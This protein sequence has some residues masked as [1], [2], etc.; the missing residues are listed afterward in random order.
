MKVVMIAISNIILYNNRNMT[1]PVG[2]DE[3]NEILIDMNDLN[4]K[5]ISEK[6]IKTVKLEN[7]KDDFSEDVLNTIEVLELENI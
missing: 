7:E 6:K 4:L 5:E 3:S 2:M 1:L